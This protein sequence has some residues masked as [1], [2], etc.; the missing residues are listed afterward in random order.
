M[1]HKA[2]AFRWDSFATELLP[3]LERCLASGASG[4]LAHFVD[5]HLRECSDP[6]EGQPLTTDW[7]TTLS[8]G[9][10]QEIGDY[11]LTPYYRPDEDFGVGDEW[12]GLDAELPGPARA[13]L[14]GTPVGPPSA[15][16]DPGRMGSYFQSPAAVARSLEVLGQFRS[17]ALTTFQHL[18]QQAKLSRL[19][20]YVTF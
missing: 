6:Y 17:P 1:C 4:D 20:V 16:F 18:L 8:A 14:L 15:L 7:R 12:L 11:A 19:G 9:D 10:V 13:A 3:L 5:A 2:F